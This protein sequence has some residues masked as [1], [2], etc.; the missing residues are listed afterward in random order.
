VGSEGPEYFD[1]LIRFEQA[2]AP[3]R[4]SIRGKIY[5]ATRMVMND[6]ADLEIKNEQPS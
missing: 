3:E 2:Q 6:I 5:W 4:K 1:N